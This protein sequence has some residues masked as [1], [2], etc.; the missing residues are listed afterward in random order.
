MSKIKMN[1][2]SIGLL[3]LFIVLAGTGYLMMHRGPSE[4]KP[5]KTVVTKIKKDK[6]IIPAHALSMRKPEHNGDAKPSMKLADE[7]YDSLSAEMKDLIN[8]LQDALDNDDA[9]AVSKIAE[10]ILVTQRKKG[11][12]AVPPFVREKTVEAIGFFLPGLLADLVGFMADSDPDVLQDVMDK[13]SESIDD[14]DL[15]DRELS[16]ILMSVGKVLSDE[17]GIDSLFLAI[18]SDM[19]NSIAVKT[20]LA[21]WENG[22]Q[23]IKD[24]IVESISDFTGEDEITTPDKLKEWLNENPDDEDDEDFYGPSK[25]DDE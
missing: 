6:K 22:T 12:D 16:S 9:K 17:D 13:F 18:E 25:D 15:G 14:P 23:E 4:K 20:Y 10:Q 21:L 19:R 1:G 24:R 11:D 5:G 3:A 7:E 8:K 2:M